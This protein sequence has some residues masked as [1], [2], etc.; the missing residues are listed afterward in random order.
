MLLELSALKQHLAAVA[1]IAFLLIED[2]ACVLRSFWVLA[3]LKR[4]MLAL[5]EAM[6]AAKAETRG[7]APASCFPHPVLTFHFNRLSFKDYTNA[8]IY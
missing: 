3:L 5:V 2:S 4:E 6:L 1:I 8:D 7:V